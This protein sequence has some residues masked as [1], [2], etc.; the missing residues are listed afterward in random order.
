MLR[1][2]DLCGLAAACRARG[3]WLVVD[4]IYHGITYEDR[5]GTALGI[6]PEAIVANSFSK[7][8][9]MTGW[10]LGWLV[11]PEELV[12]AVERLAQNLFIAAS[13]VAQVAALGAFDDQPELDRRIAAYRRNRD[14]LLAALARAGLERTAPADGAFY[15]YADVGDLTDD[16]VAFCREILERTGVALTPGVDFDEPRGHRYVRLSFAGAEEVVDE[17]ADR[18]ERFLAGRRRDMA[19]A[20]QGR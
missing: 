10:R 5:P 20:G 2:A 16:S 4:E 13:T 17:A 7:Y 8:L 6:A 18:L 15:V 11:L 3:T 9:C 14:R 1:E 12:P 19:P